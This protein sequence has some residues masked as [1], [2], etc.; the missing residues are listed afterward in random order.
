MSLS[1]RGNHNHEMRRD[2]RDTVEKIWGEPRQVRLRELA[3]WENLDN[4]GWLQLRRRETK[5]GVN[6]VQNSASTTQQLIMS[7]VLSQRLHLL[8][9]VSCRR[10]SSTVY[11]IHKFNSKYTNLVRAGVGDI[12]DASSLLGLQVSNKSTFE[13]MSLSKDIFLVPPTG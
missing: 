12:D 1:H 11:L 2:T 8:E 3:G 9:R 10:Q 4:V 13:S 6:L 5:H 7:D